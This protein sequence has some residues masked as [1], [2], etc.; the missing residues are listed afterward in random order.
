[1]V[2]PLLYDPVL[3]GIIVRYLL[4]LVLTHLGIRVKYQF[5]SA[6]TCFGFLHLTRFGKNGGQQRPSPAPT[7]AGTSYPSCAATWR[8]WDTRN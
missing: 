8:S 4:N 6:L 1:M 5:G 3:F 2:T 7:Y